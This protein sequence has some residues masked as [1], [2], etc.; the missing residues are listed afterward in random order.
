MFV[1]KTNLL[2]YSMHSAS[3]FLYVVIILT[4]QIK[5]NVRPK[6]G[7]S[8]EGIAEVTTF[9]VELRKMETHGCMLYTPT[10]ADFEQNCSKSTLTCFKLEVEVLMVEIQSETRFSQLRRILNKLTTKLKDKRKSCPVCEVYREESPETFL[11]TLQSVF[12]RMNA[13]NCPHDKTI[14]TSTS[15]NL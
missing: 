11:E 5:C 15:L 7:C 6:F 10:L 2:H 1:I 3:L 14:T 9:A 4:R 8:Y 12:Q 13:E